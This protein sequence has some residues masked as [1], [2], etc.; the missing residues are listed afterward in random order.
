MFDHCFDSGFECV[1]Q[2]R[3]LPGEHRFVLDGFDAGLDRAAALMPQYQ[4]ERRAKHGD[5]VLD[6]RQ[7]F[8]R[9]K[10]TGHADGE[11]IT[12]CSIERVL[13][14][15]ARV[16]ATQDRDERVLTGNQR[17]TLVLEVMGF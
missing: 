12:S 1:S 15:D 16:G 9:N 6:T 4:N 17:F 3:D 11:K 13:G 10:V 7:T 2:F 14:G 8:V 5:T